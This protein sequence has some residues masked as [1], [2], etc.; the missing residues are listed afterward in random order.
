MLDD[1][2][3]ATSFDLIV[4]SPPYN[5]GKPYER[6]AELKQYQE[7][8]ERVLEKLV[9]RLSSRGSLCWQ[10]GNYVSDNE[11]LP[12]D[13]LFHPILKNLGLRLR[14]RIVWT[15]GHGLHTKRRFSG[16]YEVILWYT[17]SD[18][19]EFDLDAVRVPAKY[20]G[21]RSFRGPR[22]GKPS[23]NPL[24]KNPEDVWEFPLAEI[25][26]V[27][28]NIPNVKSNHVEKTEHPCQFPVGLVERLVLALTK[29][30][31]LV[32]DPFAGVA[33]AG[34]AALLHDRRFWGCEIDAKYVSIAHDRLECALRGDALFRPHLK[35]LYDHTKSNLATIPPEWD[36]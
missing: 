32:F 1:L 3:G 21:K 34:V 16:R 5:I 13:I 11:I 22:Q 33:S 27:W 30:G 18:E 17:K 25:D 15:F 9:K 14:N 28:R 4:S 7:W 8:Q 24:G 6:K 10:V 2:P 36:I 20:P 26:D 12:L 23:G 19:Y 31:A 35:P 29:P